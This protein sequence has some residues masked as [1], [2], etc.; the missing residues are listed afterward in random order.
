MGLLLVGRRRPLLAGGVCVSAVAAAGLTL[1]VVGSRH[2]LLRQWR[3]GARVGGDPRGRGR[4][5]A[6][7]E[8]SAFGLAV[9]G[10]GRLWD[11]GHR[12]GFGGGRRFVSVFL[13]CLLFV[14]F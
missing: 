10:G 11:G 13:V 7:W 9:G 14:I 12:L 3:L 6:G 8:A 4:F 5:A 1:G 2:L